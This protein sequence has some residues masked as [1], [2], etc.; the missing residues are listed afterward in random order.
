FA[1]R[2]NTPGTAFGTWKN[3]SVT[4]SVP[5][6]SISKRGEHIGAFVRFNT[7]ANQQVLLKIAVSFS[8]IERARE[9]LNREI[10][11]WDYTRV[12]HDARAAWA[13]NLNQIQIEG[14]STEQNSIFYSALFNTM[15]MP[16]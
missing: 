5:K 13:E 16:R 2:Y 10:P 6:Q 7:S 15:R 4:D 9:F 1:A 8:S 3:E 14:A 12:E 11:E